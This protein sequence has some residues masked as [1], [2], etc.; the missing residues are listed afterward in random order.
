MCLV[1]FR[2]CETHSTLRTN[3]KQTNKEKHDTE[4]QQNKSFQNLLKTYKQNPTQNLLKNLQYEKQNKH[5]QN[6]Q[7]HTTTN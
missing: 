5:T 6:Q 4:K 3:S 1:V 2:V 7:T